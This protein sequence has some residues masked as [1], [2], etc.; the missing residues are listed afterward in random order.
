MKVVQNTLHSMA[1][2]T[3][4]NIF[5]QHMKVSRTANVSVDDET[6]EH[7]IKVE[8]IVAVKA[9]NEKELLKKRQREKR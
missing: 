5:K 4:P 8:D 9:I 2:L 7:R 1:A 6:Y 3:S